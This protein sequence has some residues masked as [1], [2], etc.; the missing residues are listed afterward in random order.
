MSIRSE[1]WK[2]LRQYGIVHCQVRASNAISF[3]CQKWDV[4]DALEPRETML[5]FHDPT[6][7]K[8]EGWAA[9]EWDMMTG[10]HGCPCYKP[11]T[12][13]VFVSDPGEVY[14]LGQGDEFEEKISKK[15]IY[16]SYA[17]CIGYGYAYAVGPMRNV[18]KRQAKNKWISL[19]TKAMVSKQGRG[20]PGDMGFQSIDG[21]SDAD[22]YACGGVGDLWHYDG[23]AWHSINVQTNAN[24]EN[25]CCAPDG[26][27]Y[28]TTNANLMVIGRYDHWDVVDQ[29]VGD[30]ILEEMAN[31]NGT[32]YVSSHE[33][34]FEIKNDL[35]V[36]TD[37]NLPKMDSY[38]HIAA[39]DG[40]FVVAGIHC[41]YMY[42]GKSW[43]KL[44]DFS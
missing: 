13:W 17:K 20:D 44:F 34:I 18:Y 9:R 37:L 31:F 43:S 26:R 2:R 23:K 33:K 5:F 25:I 22:I 7:P 32:V 4:D 36:E 19:R 14:V 35:L 24:L 16:I 40:V 38:A 42:N 28:I 15:Q 21:F 6:M 1:V 12:K 8:A 3:S 30:Y 29:D 39:G 10:V 11:N 41:A 27:T